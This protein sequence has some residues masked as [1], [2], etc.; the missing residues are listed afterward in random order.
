MDPDW[1]VGVSIGSMNAALIAGNPPERRVEALREFWK[2]VTVRPV[3]GFIPDGD[4]GRKMHNLW[5]SF[6]TMSQGQPGLFIPNMPSPWL[7][8]RGGHGA[9]AYYDSSPMRETLVRLVDFGRLNSG[10]I[11]FAVGAV[12][13]AT[14]N[15]LYFD[16]AETTIEPDHIMASGALPPS[17]PMIQIGHDYYWD[18]GIV[19]NTPLQHLLDHIDGENA[20]VFQVDLFSARGPVPRDMAETLGRTKDIH[21]SSRTRLTTDYY[22]RSHA[23]RIQIKRLLDKIPDEQLS[24]EERDMKTRLTTLPAISILQ[25]IYQ[26]AAHV[27]VRR[28]TT[29]SANPRCGTIGPPG[30]ATRGRRW[31]GGSGW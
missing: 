4:F 15:F 16:N 24:N 9:T 28:R 12:D 22:R 6:M 1:L 18:G 26:Q 3:W 11:R 25:L 17:L 29:I 7:R 21:Y 23:Q 10:E 27:K 14:G 8:P 5:S 31:R 19:S 20:L 30:W 13:V 2:L